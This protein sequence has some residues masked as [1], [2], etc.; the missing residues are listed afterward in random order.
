MGLQKEK[1]LDRIGRNI[2]SALQENA[3]LSLAQIG[4]KVGLSSPAVAE[5]V[6]KLEE[7]GIIEG[8]HARVDPD[9][10]GES[11]AAFVHLT[12]DARNYPSV[13]K[14]AMKTPQIISCH[15]VSGEASFILH[16]RVSSL[17]GLESTVSALSP[18]GQTQTFIV[19]ST[20]VDKPIRGVFEE[21]APLSSA[22]N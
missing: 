18:F 19:L 8:Y 11:V 9:T 22:Q 21:S 1:L 20:P 16:V 14:I 12:T 5:R 4:K 7:A 13:Q 15:H 17:A 2:L 3:R 10:L 6:K